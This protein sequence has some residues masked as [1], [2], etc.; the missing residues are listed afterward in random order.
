MGLKTCDHCHEMISTNTFTCPKCGGWQKRANVF[1]LGC[2]F[3][4]FILPDLID[5]FSILFK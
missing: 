4:F 1:I 3:V 2:G 5:A